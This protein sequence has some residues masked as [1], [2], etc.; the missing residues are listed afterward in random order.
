MPAATRC[1]ATNYRQPNLKEA[2]SW[3][4]CEAVDWFV[5]IA[6]RQTPGFLT[7]QACQR[8]RVNLV[9]HEK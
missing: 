7:V 1:K 6:I 3:C 5:H 2:Y 9:W 4:L 8:D